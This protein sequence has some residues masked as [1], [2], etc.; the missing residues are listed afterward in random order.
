MAAAAHVGDPDKEPLLV[1]VWVGVHFLDAGVNAVS[2][3]EDEVFFRFQEV[4]RD[5]KL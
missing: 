5:N 1:D 2:D 4:L 3:A